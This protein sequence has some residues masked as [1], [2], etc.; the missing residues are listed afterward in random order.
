MATQ[1]PREMFRVL[2]SD[3]VE[4]CIAIGHR[5]LTLAVDVPD[6]QA[7]LAAHQIGSEVLEVDVCGDGACGVHALCESPNR[8]AS[9]YC[10]KARE[11]I[12]EKLLRP[13]ID[14]RDCRVVQS[15]EG[16]QQHVGGVH[17]RDVRAI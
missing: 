15:G 14:T 16:E 10:A 1:R 17:C 6:A 9:L 12:R 3:I 13:L 2:A 5:H 4:K 7:L 8:S 11:L